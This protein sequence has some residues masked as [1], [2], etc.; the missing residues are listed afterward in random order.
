MK[1]A[2]IVLIFSLLVLIALLVVFIM[3]RPKE[4][5]EVTEKPTSKLE[6]YQKDLNKDADK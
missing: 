3:S 4:E 5:S 2:K 6:Q 1:K